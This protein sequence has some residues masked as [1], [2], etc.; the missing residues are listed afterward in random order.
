MPTPSRRPVLARVADAF[1]ALRGTPSSSAIRAVIPTSYPNGTK[2]AAYVRTANPQEYKPEGATIRTQGFSRHPV[3]HSCIRVVADLIASVPLVVERERGNSE[4]RVPSS[5]P[6]QQLL[7]MPGPRFTA[8]AFRSRFAVDFLGYG[9]AIFKLERSS[10]NGPI[11]GMRP[12]NPEAV[13]S[14][15]VDASGDAARWDVSNWA[16]IVENIPALDI[17]HFKD[18]EMPRPFTADVFGF[19]RGAATI[20]SLIADIEATNY[21]RQIVT[22]DGTPTFA[23]LMSDEATSDDARAMQ[24]R[25][26]ERVVERGN[27]GKPA[28]FGGVK[29]IK[30]L[31]FTL[32]DLEFPDLRR[33]SREDICAAFGVDPRMVGI[34]SASNDGGL[35]GVQYAE[36]RARL[37]QHTIE[38]ILS[39]FE[40]EINHWLSPEYGDVWV[41]YDANV[42]RDL[43]ENDTETST[44]IRAEF[45]ASLRTFEESRTAL[46][47]SPLP[48]PTDALWRP[49]GASLIPSAVA[50]IDPTTVTAPEAPDQITA[51]TPTTDGEDGG[52][53]GAAQSI[54][55]TEATVLNGAQVSS[56]QAI[57][58]AVAEGKL[59]RDA[60]IAMI[61]TFFN[62]TAEVATEIMGSAGLGTVTT[63][64][65]PEGGA[66]EPTAPAPPPPPARSVRM[67]RRGYVRAYAEDALD[68]EQIEQLVELL[69]TCVES[70]LP[71]MT[72]KAVI[73]AAFP[74]IDTALVDEMLAGLVGFTPPE[75]KPEEPEA[76]A[77]PEAV[78]VAPIEAAAAVPDVRR[79][80]WL[81]VQSKLDAEE[82]QYKATAM[83]LFEEQGK[84]VEASIASARSERGIRVDAIYAEAL[85]RA[86]ANY[87]PGG[88]YHR[89][90]AK[91]YEKLIGRTFIAG[92]KDV[93][94][95]LSFTLQSPQVQKAIA[96]RTTQLATYVGDTTSRQIE[97][98]IL[99]AEKAGMSVAE[100]ARLVRATAYGEAMTEAR[101][102][103]I[104]RTESAQA[105]SQ[106]SWDQ[107]KADGVY[108]KK[109]WLA[110]DDNEVRETH[111]ANMDEGP[112]AIDNSFKANGL[113]YPLD[114]AGDADEVINCRCTLTYSTD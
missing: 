111:R 98:A 102:T 67:E 90:W 60:G 29:D 21:V 44:R 100:T 50:V 54:Q 66:V 71:M 1:R 94:V 77:A 48:E 92:A 57:V 83:R 84:E 109:E 114:P 96:A 68:G 70:E 53:P 16:G 61:K 65:K 42:L 11:V 79:E 20:Q 87:A 95:G 2:Q 23:V 110:F 76:P 99:A 46:K 108:T 73:L 81:R 47:L 10:P 64:N 33:V 106:G 13:Q 88:K 85:R 89:Q 36:A 56:A 41:S 107:A 80:K 18:L 74:M 39:A 15:W 37:V 40:D 34:A 51:G 35:S 7:D 59:P 58:L 49:M 69:E 105:M 62:L 14:V 30:D 27:R 82:R 9:N 86:K 17:L 75:E 31:G 72:V 63:P 5:H 93:A 8:R 97:A 22:N 12:L 112:I 104:A 25:Y 26:T 43:V 24:D 113:Q 3:V 45:A 52:A 103:T 78:P 4:S 6:L 19:P 38:P 32:S 91:A 55:T 101:S 28:F